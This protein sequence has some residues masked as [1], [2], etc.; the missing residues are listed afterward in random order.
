MC[1]YAPNQV[2]KCLGTARYLKDF[3]GAS[4]ATTRDCGASCSSSAASERRKPKH[5]VVGMPSLVQKDWLLRA[6]MPQ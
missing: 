1:F 4:K 3:A 5:T 6:T 2:S